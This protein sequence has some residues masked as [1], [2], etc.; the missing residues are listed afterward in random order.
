MSYIVALYVM[1]AALA[2]C[3]RVTTPASRN[4]ADCETAGVYVPP[5]TAAPR[6]GGS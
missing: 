1:L 2:G 3:A 5:A 4:N 6:C